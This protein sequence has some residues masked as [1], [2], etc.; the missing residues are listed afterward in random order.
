LAWRPDNNVQGADRYFCHGFTFGGSNAP[1]GPFSPYGAYVVTILARGFNLIPE[2][3]A[4]AG[5]IVVWY[6]ANNQVIHS[7]VLN[8]VVI[9][10]G[11]LDRERTTLRTKNGRLPLENNM[12]LE[13]VCNGP[14]VGND[15]EESP[16]YGTTYRV[17]RAR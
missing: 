5:D 3:N 14:L 10:D 7:A 2:A 15:A 13:R 1:N 16:G 17:Y 4:R 9:N 11:R 12:T 8:N 6:D